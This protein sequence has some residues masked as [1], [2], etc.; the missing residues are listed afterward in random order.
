MED[1]KQKKQFKVL[2]SELKEKGIVLEKREMERFEKLQGLVPM[3]FL[4]KGS[5]EMTEMSKV[6]DVMNM[7]REA[8][9][10]V[11]GRGKKFMNKIECKQMVMNCVFLTLNERFVYNDEIPSATQRK[12]LFTDLKNNLWLWYR[13]KNGAMST[14]DMWEKC[15]D[16]EI[17]MNRF[18]ILGESVTGAFGKF[19]ED[20]Y[21]FYDVDKWDLENKKGKKVWDEGEI[22]NTDKVIRC[23]GI[24]IKKPRVR[25]RKKKE[26]KEFGVRKKKPRIYRKKDVIPEEKL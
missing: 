13:W 1:L 18:G 25:K 9:K 15:V 26:E 2:V 19:G 20:K 10:D 4:P 7:I 21:I 16:F 6:G 22:L 12:E 8:W 23:G 11:G 24:R 17:K 5:L 14:D 3:K